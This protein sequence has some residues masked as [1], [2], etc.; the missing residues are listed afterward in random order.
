MGYSR[1]PFF[2]NTLVLLHYKLIKV[3]LK[4]PSK[5]NEYVEDTIQLYTVQRL[6][7]PVGGLCCLRA[8]CFLSDQ[9]VFT[10]NLVGQFSL[11]LCFHAAAAHSHL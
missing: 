5:Q 6:S 10:L 11:L 7:C 9:L 1:L 2:Q 3:C 4:R 8:S